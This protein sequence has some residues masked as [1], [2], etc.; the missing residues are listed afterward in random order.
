MDAQPVL[1]TLE[2]RWPALVPGPV[3]VCFELRG[4]PGHKARHRSRIV[5]G[6]EL[7]VHSARDSFIPKAN[8]KKIFIQ[9]YPDPDTAAYEK[10]LAECAALFMRGRRATDNPVALLVHAFRAIPAS[11]SKTDREKAR[12]G[13]IMPTSRPD[14]DNHLKVVQDALNKI[15]WADDSQVVDS[16]CIKKYHEEPALRIEVREMLP[17][18]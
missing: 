17:P 13:A 16:R 4:P 14:G 15:V 10:T 8:V 5:I 9:Q 12:D 1:P 2:M 3:F 18:T 7:W 11:W 6:R